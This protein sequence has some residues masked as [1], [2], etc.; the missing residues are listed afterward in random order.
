[1]NQPQ[2]PCCSPS[3]IHSHNKWCCWCLV[4]DSAFLDWSR[5]HNIW[6]ISS[7]VSH[8]TLFLPEQS[9]TEWSAMMTMQQHYS[10]TNKGNR[11]IMQHHNPSLDGKK[12]QSVVSLPLL[13]PQMLQ[14][15][16][17]ILASIIVVQGL[18]PGEW[19]QNLGAVYQIAAILLLFIGPYKI[20]LV[21]S[22]DNFLFLFCSLPADKHPKASAMD[23]EISAHNNHFLSFR[24]SWRILASLTVMINHYS[25]NQLKMIDGS[26]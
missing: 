22:E 15:N 2:K 12:N 1:M 17:A 9:K 7:G 10:Y 26:C 5:F 16:T 18:H 4:Y 20:I 24:W 14:L 6:S 25:N 21:S 3:H 23:Q 13:L 11:P 19:M 8:Q